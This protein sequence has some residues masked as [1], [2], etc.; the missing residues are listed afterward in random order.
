MRAC[1][2]GF[3]RSDRPD[4]LKTRTAGRVTAHLVK[5][6]SAPEKGTGWHRHEADFQIVTMTKDWAKFMYGE[7]ETLIEAGDCLHRRPSIELAGGVRSPGTCF[8]VRARSE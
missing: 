5:A 1:T 4:A 7:Q 2:F 6:N 3:I 8:L